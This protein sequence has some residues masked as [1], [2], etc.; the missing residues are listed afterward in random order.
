MELVVEGDEA[1][2]TRFLAEIASAMADQI[3]DRQLEK[4]ASTGEFVGFEIR[5]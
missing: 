5:R 2:M 3:R 4:G 1:E